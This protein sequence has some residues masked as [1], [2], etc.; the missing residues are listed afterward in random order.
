LTPISQFDSIL[1]ILDIR[2]DSWQIFAR[3]TNHN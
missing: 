3:K 2:Y 1:I